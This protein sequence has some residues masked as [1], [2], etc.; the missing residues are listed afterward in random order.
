MDNYYKYDLL[1]PQKN[2]SLYRSRKLLRL[3]DVVMPDEYETSTFYKGFMI[4]QDTHDEMVITLTHKNKL[5]G[6]LGL[7]GKEKFTFTSKDCKRF[8]MMSELIGTTFVYQHQSDPLLLTEREKDVVALVKEGK[9]N[10]EIAEQLFISH[11]TVKNIYKIFI[12]NM[13]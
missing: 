6:V 10:K 11:N 9:T 5:V 8:L 7:G 3:I 4:P 1:H 2:L 13:E 12:E